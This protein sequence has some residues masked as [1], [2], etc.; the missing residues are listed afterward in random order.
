MNDL[1]WIMLSFNQPYE[2][3]S[4]GFYDAFNSFN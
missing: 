1:G 3:K 4:G 2:G